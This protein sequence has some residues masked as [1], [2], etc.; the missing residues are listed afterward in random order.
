MHTH[1]H[2][3]HSSS[4]DNMT[5]LLP[6]YLL[7][8][9]SL[10]FWFSSK[11]GVYYTLFHLLPGFLPNQDLLYTLL[12]PFEPL[13]A[14]WANGSTPNPPLH[15]IT[16]L[17]WAIISWRAQSSFSRRSMTCSS[18]WATRGSW[19]QWLQGRTSSLVSSCSN[20]LRR[21]CCS[22]RDFSRSKIWAACWSCRCLMLDSRSSNLFTM[23][24]FSDSAFSLSSRNMEVNLSSA[25]LFRSSCECSHSASFFWNSCF[26]SWIFSSAVFS[27]T[28]W[29]STRLCL[30]YKTTWFYVRGKKWENA[31]TP[32][33]PLNMEILQFILKHS[34]G[35][36]S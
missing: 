14:L 10:L 20:C 12:G 1:V 29:S 6:A 22:I 36:T 7:W 16:H 28:W 8:S 23:D 5:M 2:A 3:R 4:T 21:P 27:F 11:N 19:P 24:C 34:S 9:T 25:S 32:S 35:N 31:V 30:T 33:R 18:S 17:F 15:N 13:P 26:S